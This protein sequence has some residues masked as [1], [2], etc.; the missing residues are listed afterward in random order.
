MTTDPQRITLTELYQA[1]PAYL[2]GAEPFDVDAGLKMLND[3]I[4]AHP[5]QEVTRPRPVYFETPAAY[6]QV[7]QVYLASFVDLH[8]PAA[9]GAM[10]VLR[11]WREDPPKDG[12]E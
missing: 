1:L 4:D 10:D 5:D 3:W 7:M 8:Q 11:T 9:E 6:E 12:W 2:D